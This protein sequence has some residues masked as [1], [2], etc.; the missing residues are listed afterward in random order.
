MTKPNKAN[1]FITDGDS[2]TAAEVKCR[3]TT[4]KTE[5]LSFEVN[6]IMIGAN[7]EEVERIIEK[8]RR[9]KRG[10]KEHRNN[11]HNTRKI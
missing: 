2:V 1:G 5:I 6:G 3:L 9:K 8:I 11:H 7:Y 4:G 10:A